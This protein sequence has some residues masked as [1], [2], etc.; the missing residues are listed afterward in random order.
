[1]IAMPAH[2]Y[3]VR[4]RKDKR[5]FDLISDALSFGVLWCAESNRCQES[6]RKGALIRPIGYTARS[7]E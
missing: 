5:G 2:L 7:Y 1:M 4:P 3:E 6:M